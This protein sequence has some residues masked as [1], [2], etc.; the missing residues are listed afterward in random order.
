MVVTGNSKNKQIKGRK[1]LWVIVDY[2]GLITKLNDAMD[3]YTG[4]GLENLIWRL[5]GTM[6]DVLSAVGLREANSILIDFLGVKINRHRRSRTFSCWWKL[7]ENFTIFYAL[8][9]KSCIEFEIAYASR[10]KEIKVYQDNF[11]FYSK[12]VGLSNKVSWCNR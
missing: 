2:R 11:L 1:R 5:K 9:G 4:A 3:M 12:F 10:K 8:K 7:R 6:V